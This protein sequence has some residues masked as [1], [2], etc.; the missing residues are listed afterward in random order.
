MTVKV[1]EVEGKRE[2][3][4]CGERVRK[5]VRGGGRGKRKFG[6]VIRKGKGIQLDKRRRK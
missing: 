2:G 1:G 6:R 5:T 3:K 4:L